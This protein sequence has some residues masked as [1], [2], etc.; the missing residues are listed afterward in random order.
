MATIFVEGLG[1]V[2]IQGDTP[3]EEEQQAIIDALGIPSTD[4]EDQY[5]DELPDSTDTPS[6]GSEDIGAT[7]TIIPEIIDP[8]LSK[9]GKPEPKG[10]EKIGIDRPVF[11]AAGAIFGS[12]PGAAL[13]PP[14]IVAGGTL[15][16]AGTG[17]LHDIIQSTITDEPTDFGTQMVRLKKDLT[18][19]ALLQSFFAK[20]PGM[21]TG[22]KKFIWGKPDKKLYDSAKKINFPLSLSD[23]GNVISTGYGKI[24]GVF[25]YVGGPVKTAASKKALFLNKT[26]DDTLNTF[27]PN[28]TLSKLGLDMS[29]AAQVTYGDFRRVSSFFYDDFYKAVDKIG[30][31]PVISTKHFKN[32]LQKYVTKINDGTIKGAVSPQKD[33]IYQ[34]AKKNVKKIPNY[35]NASQYRNLKDD[36]KYFAKLSK[37]EPF[38][39]KVLTG[40]KSSLETDL[41]LLN[42]QSYRDNLL[43]NVY[44]LTKSKAKNLDPNIL[45]DIAT[46]LRFA[47]KVYATGLENSLITSVMKKQAQKE[48][49]KLVSIPGK[50]VF[51]E[52]TANIFKKVDKNIFGTGF[53][54]PG[55]LNADELAEALL[56][57]KAGPTFLKD[58]RT[59]VGEGQYNKFVRAKLQKAYNSSLIQSG[60]TKPS[61]LMFDPYKFE[62]SLGMDTAAGRDL[63][64]EMLKGSKVTLEQLDSFFNVA[65]NHAGLKIP[66]VSS[67]VARRAVLGG[68]KSLLGGVV[69][70]AGIT[71]NPLV[72]APLIYM[73]RKTSGFLANP[74]AL[75]DVVKVFDPNSTASQMKVAALKLMDAL[76]SESRN[77]IE[78]NEL[79]LYREYLELMPLSEIKKGVEDTLESSEEFLNMNQ[80]SDVE[81]PNVE[82]PVQE[83]RNLPQDNKTFL[84]ET[85]G[86]NPAFFN[87]ATMNQGVADN[88][89]L[90][91]SEHAFLDDQEKMMRLR[92]RGYA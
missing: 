77:K 13:G 50:K 62:K 39:I 21:W 72:A 9:V 45:S 41:R 85:P 12:V 66:D 55:S 53:K 54:V 24:I 10:L 51:D 88:T 91:S 36:I 48:G 22:T 57:R 68:T 78:K 67:F 30:N 76:I 84:P 19:E 60:G 47:D 81:S 61:G 69:M 58:L 37:K 35:I 92:Q 42:K 74:K 75:D 25:P 82:E 73:A 90:T 52:P 34:Y 65:K 11:E 32:S 16:A 87:T 56:K 1:N 38:N 64:E 6:L 23:S 44:P 26:A 43:K 63:L 70:G 80:D 31:T 5:L 49:V 59:L 71:S 46:R 20:I 8:N 83:N 40:L 14:G 7:E 17:Q 29:K 28:V 27:A 4:I 86:V 18:R 89:G 79:S 3:T 2:D 15:G 33:A